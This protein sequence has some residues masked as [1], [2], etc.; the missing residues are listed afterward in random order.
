MAREIRGLAPTGST[1]YARI[2][3][4]AGLWWN[5]TTFEA[6]AA[7]NYATY[8]VA[9]TE[10]GA[11]GLFVGDFPTGITT[12]GTYEYFCYIQAGGTP[13]QGDALTNSGSVDWTGSA[14][15]SASASSMTASDF[16]AY[17]L[18]KGFKRTD[19]STE[20]Y[21]AI[22]DA[23]QELRARF[24]FDEAGTDATT[25]DT[26]A[27]LGDYKLSLESDFGMI[28]T[29]TL[30]DGE[31]A[32]PLVKLTKDEF[33]AIYPYAANDTTFRGYPQHYC[34]YAGQ[35]Y[36]GPTPDSVS[37]TYRL[38]YSKRAGTVDSTTAAVPFT[39]VYR[40]M[41][42]NLV[43][44]KLYAGLEDYDKAGWHRQEHESMFLAATR[45][46]RKN[47]GNSTFVMAAQD[48]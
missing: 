19:K 44:A 37:Y 21:E 5:G 6:Y 9:L 35:I 8:D 27:T 4:P 25:T 45:R 3:S 15:V 42:A 24:M 26:I 30:Q 29:V 20:V 22:T 11:S 39:D 48:F 18:R 1:V 41:L 43:L 31:D 47:G 16:Y 10:Q 7:G 13:A 32:T 46:E 23:V 33:N 38:A 28:L 34:I 40:E 12:A 17:V 14:A 2:M 36:L